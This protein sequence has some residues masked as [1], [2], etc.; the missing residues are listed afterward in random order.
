MPA[1][2][3]Y[4]HISSGRLKALRAATSEFRNLE[5]VLKK[6]GIIDPELLKKLDVLRKLLHHANG[7]GFE[8][9]ADEKL[10]NEIIGIENE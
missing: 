8:E 1:D 10:L 7:N 5:K 9:L 3:R 2:Y 4:E 6:S